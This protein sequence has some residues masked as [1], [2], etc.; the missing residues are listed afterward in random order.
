MKKILV[1]N[2]H[3][4]GS[5]ERFCAALADAYADGA[6]A[7]CHEVRRIKVAGLEF[8]LI[9]SRAEFE[10]GA[11]PADIKRAQADI[12]WADH[13]VLVHPLW[14]GGPPA[15]LKGFLEQVFRYGFALGKPGSDQGMGLLKGRTARVIVT[16]GMPSPVY[17]LVFGAFGVR[18]I[19][20]GIL[21][22]SGIGPIGRTL[23]GGIE[24]LT[25]R[26]REEI[27]EKVARLGRAAS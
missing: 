23:V 3:P 5:P 7:L 9:A 17:R 16:M 6:S 10:K 11:V 12:K 26:Q 15:L 24:G 21:S 2:G 13:I 14:L 8:P 22:I 19:E 1:I 18:A 25:G 4:D 27:L 20:R